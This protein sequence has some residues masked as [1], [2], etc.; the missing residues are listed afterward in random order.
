MSCIDLQSLILVR[1]QRECGRRQHREKLHRYKPVITL[2]WYGKNE[3]RF[4]AEEYNV[5]QLD[6]RDR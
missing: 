6:W 5:H 2:V 1:S 3:A 4:E